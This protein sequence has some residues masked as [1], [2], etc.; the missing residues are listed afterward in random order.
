MQV[1]FSCLCQLCLH[2]LRNFQD[3]Q[4]HVIIFIGMG[5]VCMYPML[6]NI[7]GNNLMFKTA[8]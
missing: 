4:A 6:L 8:H 2:W 5:T 3:F 1:L 7:Y